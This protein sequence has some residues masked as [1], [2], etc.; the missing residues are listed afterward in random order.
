MTPESNNNEAEP[1]LKRAFLLTEDTIR[2]KTKMQ[3]K[4]SHRMKEY[5]SGSL[6]A[7]TA[8]LGWGCG[9]G[10]FVCKA[11]GSITST[12]GFYWCVMA[13]EH[14][15]AQTAQLMDRLSPEQCGPQSWT[16]LKQVS[17]GAGERG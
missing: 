1:Y 5:F 17:P 7:R 14:S 3:E 10:A 8:N 11:L 4:V 6:Q 9:S 13:R 16:M 15:V 2:T 12:T